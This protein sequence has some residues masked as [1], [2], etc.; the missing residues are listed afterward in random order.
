MWPLRER[1]V[2][3]SLGY[4]QRDVLGRR[5]ECVNSASI[6]E[7]TRKEVRERNNGRARDLFIHISKR[8]LA[9]LSGK[10]TRPTTLEKENGTDYPSQRQRQRSQ[11]S[12]LVL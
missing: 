8:S 7:L 12:D 1:I 6:A 5:T 2:R 3:V 10:R 11:G 9:R 4:R